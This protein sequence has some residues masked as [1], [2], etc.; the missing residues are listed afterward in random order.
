I[1]S[2]YLAHQRA[3]AEVALARLAELRLADDDTEPDTTATDEEADLPANA[4]RQPLA[5][6]RRAAVLD[7]LRR[8]GATRVLDL[9]CGD[10]ALLAE[11]VRD[12][13]YT[14]IVGA[15]VSPRALA[16]AERRLD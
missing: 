4:R 1:T 6:Q 7:A 5:A 15:D 10:G 8:A 14:E 3:L 12:P 16:L 9:G 2:R 11:L 13:R